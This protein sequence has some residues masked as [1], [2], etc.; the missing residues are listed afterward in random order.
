[1]HGFVETED[2]AM[3]VLPAGCSVTWHWLHFA[4]EL[5]DCCWE[6]WNCKRFIQNFLWIHGISRWT[7]V[8]RNTHHRNGLPPSVLSDSFRLLQLCTP[9]L[10]CLGQMYWQISDS[11]LFFFTLAFRIAF[12]MNHLLLY[13]S[14]GISPSSSTSINEQHTHKYCCQHFFL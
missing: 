7:R 11:H 3:A 13:I 8:C 4:W 1:M 2:S 5:R 10:C 12:V 14:K 9:C 6:T